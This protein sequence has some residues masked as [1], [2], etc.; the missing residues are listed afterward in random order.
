[1]FSTPA[2]DGLVASVAELVLE[3][4]HVHNKLNKSEKP[5]KTTYRR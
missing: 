1:M 4:L 2:K 3:G 5:G